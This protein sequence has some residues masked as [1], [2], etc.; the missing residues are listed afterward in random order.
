MNFTSYHKL[1]EEILNS[2][3]QQAPYDKADYLNYTKLNFSRTSRWLKQT[4]I[5]D[6][7]K[8]FFGTIKQVQNW[9]L[10]TEPW[11]G[12]A[13]HSVPF[14][15]LLSQLS[16]KIKLKI[17][18]RDFG[19]EIENYLTNGGKSIPILIIRN[20]ENQDLAV[21]GP[22]PAKCQELFL[23]MKTKELD[24]EQQKIELQ[25]WYN[26]DKGQSII[27]ELIRILKGI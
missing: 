20:E 12:D 19:S 5:K 24:F 15:Y 8:H 6:E 23:E 26:M 17:Q 3:K 11:C 18:L 13:A 1:F 22:R 9:V 2:E 27:E 14:I 16:D 7:I 21:W 25:N 10:I 4:E